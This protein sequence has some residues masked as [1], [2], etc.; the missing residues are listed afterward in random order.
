MALTPAMTPSSTSLSTS[1]AAMG[2][3]MSGPLMSALQQA[4]AAVEE[5]T[6]LL[7]DRQKAI[8]LADRSELGCSE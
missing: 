6:A 2:S 1:S 8:R 7:K 3:L 5:G 4:K